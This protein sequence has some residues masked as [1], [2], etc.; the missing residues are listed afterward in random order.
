LKVKK[1]TFNLNHSIGIACNTNCMR[2]QSPWGICGAAT[3][4]KYMDFGFVYNLE[5]FV[6]L[7]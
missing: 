2:S 7:L 1:L 5:L 6:V 3:V 4:A